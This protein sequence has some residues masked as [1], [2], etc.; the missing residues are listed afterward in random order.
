[1]TVVASVDPKLLKNLIDMNK[2]D[3]GSSGEYTDMIVMGF[4]ESKQERAASA[5]ADFVKAWMLAKESFAMSEKNPAMRVIEAVAYHFS[6]HRNLKI[7]LMNGK[8]K[9]ISEHMVLMI[10]P[11]TLRIWKR[12]NWRSIILTSRRI[13]SSS[14]LI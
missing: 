5:R 14:L 3:A 8:L 12:A 1:M 13:P 9:K 7:H 6:F 4:L 11:A 10:R 2:I